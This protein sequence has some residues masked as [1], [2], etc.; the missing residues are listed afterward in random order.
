MLFRSNDIRLGIPTPFPTRTRTKDLE[1][2]EDSDELL[3]AL[4]DEELQLDDVVTPAPPTFLQQDPHARVIEPGEQSSV[5]N[6]ALRVPG[7]M[8]FT[9]CRK[10]YCLPS[11]RFR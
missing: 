10:I 3:N 5:S 6:H 8:L 11:A 9:F 7:M 1:A 2:E 4:E